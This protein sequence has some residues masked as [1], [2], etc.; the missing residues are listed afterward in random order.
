MFWGGGW[1]FLWWILIIVV[2]VGAVSF[3]VRQ[4]GNSIREKSALDLLKE[5]YARGEI[6]KQEFEEKKRDIL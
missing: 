4:Q 6:S 1:M 5:R 2:I 3:F